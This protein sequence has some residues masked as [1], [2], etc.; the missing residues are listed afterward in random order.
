M[1][2]N[3]KEQTH[4]Q[5]LQSLKTMKE[6]P[7]TMSLE[8]YRTIQG[9]L[10]TDKNGYTETPLAMYKRVASTAAKKL[11][12]E[13]PSLEYN[14]VYSDF[15]TVIKNNWLGLSTP[16]A[17]NL[18]TPVDSLPISCFVMSVSDSINGIF[19]SLH[20]ASMLTKA[21]GGVGIDL[22]PIR[23][24]GI[25][26]NGGG[27]SNGS[28][29]WATIYD[30]AS[31]IVS[32]AGVRRGQFSFNI[33]IESPDLW[34]YLLSKDHSKGDPRKHIHS[35]ICVN[36]TDA[37]MEKLY[38]NDSE[39]INRWN[40][41][42]RTRLISGSPYLHFIDNANRDLVQCMK[43]L[44]KTVTST[45][46]CCF[47]GDTKVRTIDGEY[48]IRDLVGKT[49]KIHNGSAWVNNSEFSLSGQSEL[50]Q[51]TLENGEILRLTPNH[52][53]LIEFH[54]APEANLPKVIVEKLAQDLKIG[55]IMCSAES[56]SSSGNNIVAMEMMEGLHDVYCTKVDSTSYFVLSNGIL[57][58]NTEITSCSDKDNTMV[59]CLASENLYKYDEWK[60][61][62]GE[63]G[64]GL[65]EVSIY[66]L[67][68]VMQYFIDMTKDTIRFPKLERAR[69]YAIN[70]R[71]LG[72][73]VF[74]YHAYMMKK[75]MVFGSIDSKV[76]TRDF[77]EKLAKDSNA[78]STRLAKIC[79]SGPSPWAGERRNIQVTSIAPT[80]GNSVVNDGV[81]PGIEPL[82][83]NY[84]EASGASGS[85]LRKNP[86]LEELLE[87]KGLNTSKTWEDILKHAG[88]VAHV[89][90]LTEREKEVFKTFNEIDQKDIIT[91]AEI[92]QWYLEQTQ[93][94]NLSFD[95]S[96]SPEYISDVHIMAYQ[97]GLHTLYYLRSESVQ[98]KALRESVSEISEDKAIINGESTNDF[99]TVVFKDDCIWCDKAKKLLSEYNMDVTYIHK[100]MDAGFSKP[101][102]F[103]TYPQIYKNTEFLGGYNAL[104]E[105]LF[106]HNDQTI[107]DDGECESCAD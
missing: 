54:H 36:V 82:E 18:G 6:A 44:G 70:G 7:E 50:L 96:A 85:F 69:N 93:S 27:H 60:N 1:I 58:G 65:H 38:I 84:Y 74:G 28:K 64:L 55:H 48:S 63:L 10:F 30:I 90:Y 67:D 102:G 101:D 83:A 87:S 8:A 75:G 16:V 95:L 88:S 29:P 61:W 53:C 5:Q 77:F 49:V 13:A 104:R 97:K 80:V 2:T 40:A 42:L 47:H 51:I 106:N 45:N 32:Q 22:T 37:F 15:L 24:Q 99:Y 103:N 4:E 94:V 41:V 81:T 43:D 9:C 31:G 46:I 98:K 78:A 17:A 76:F 66:F 52:R 26:I 56:V 12:Q 11:I 68:S 59:C 72:L 73:G 91:L 20:E 33:D 35:N 89:E 62:I 79:T 100:D 57:I 92:R 25:S 34:D 14:S 107:V 86:I 39:A 21:G 105:S 19:D 71:P 23:P 3:F